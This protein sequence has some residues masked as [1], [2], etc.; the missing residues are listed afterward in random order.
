LK[1][2]SPDLLILVGLHHGGN[3]EENISD[4]WPQLVSGQREL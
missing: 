3:L 4:P 2:L 1:E